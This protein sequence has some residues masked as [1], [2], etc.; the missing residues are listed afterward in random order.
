MA[1]AN[2]ENHRC[3]SLYVGDLAQKVTEAEL[4]EKFSTVGPIA[5]IHLCRDIITRRS[6]RY[7]YVNFHRPSDA[8]TAMDSLNFCELLGQPIRIMWPQ[9]NPACRKLGIGNIFIKNL[10]KTV[11]SK[12]LFDTFSTFGNILSCKVAKDRNGNSRGH[13]FVHFDSSEAATIAISQVNGMLLNGRKV[14]VSNFIARKDREPE[15][16]SNE[17]GFRN[18]YVKNF[19]DVLDNDKLLEIFSKYGQIV[20]HKVI[21]NIFYATNSNSFIQVNYY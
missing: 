11:D 8:E 13:G 10:D 20:S 15:H 21:S 14:V 6:L 7:A 3:S 1:V 16:P 17:S 4:F 2:G 18:I 5:S 19:G 12:I 9:R